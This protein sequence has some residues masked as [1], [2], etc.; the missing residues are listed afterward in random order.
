VSGYSSSQEIWRV[1]ATH[2]ES[3]S[4]SCDEETLM[5]SWPEVVT[6]AALA[7]EFI[8]GGPARCQLDAKHVHATCNAYLIKFRSGSKRRSY[9]GLRSDLR[10]PPRAGG[11]EVAERPSE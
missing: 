8:R 7:R 2:D 9:A 5:A 11:R 1:V 6:Q 4:V 10:S 3:R